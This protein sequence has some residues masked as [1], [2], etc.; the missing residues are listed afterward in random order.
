LTLAAYANIGGA[1]GAL[2]QKAEEIYQGLAMEAKDAARQLFLRLVTLGEG[3]EDTRRRIMRSELNALG[4]ADVME[5]VVSTFGSQRL[6]TFDNDPQNASSHLP[7]IR[8]P[9]C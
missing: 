3:Q 2:A 8:S 1:M 5:T 4:Q 7:C 6:L 9:D